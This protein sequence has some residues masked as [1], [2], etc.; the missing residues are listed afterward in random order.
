MNWKGKW[1]DPNWR[2]WRS[3][4]MTSWELWQT[5]SSWRLTSKP[6]WRLWRRRMKR[7]CPQGSV[8][9]VDVW[10]LPWKLSIKPLVYSLIVSTWHIHENVQRSSAIKYCMHRTF[11]HSEHSIFTAL[12]LFLPFHFTPSVLSVC[13]PQAERGGDRLEEE[14]GS[15]VWNGGQEETF[16]CW[17]V[18]QQMS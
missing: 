1:A 15:Y 7:W 16:Q 14:C 18:N 4:R 6:T 3:Q 5:P 13:S 10:A 11:V 2:E 17:T 9:L 8:I 12:L